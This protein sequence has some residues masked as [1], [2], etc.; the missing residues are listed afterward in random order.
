VLR[1]LNLFALLG[2]VAWLARVPDWEPAITSL[3]LLAALLGQE[4]PLLR[5]HREHDATLLKKFSADFPSQGRTALFLRDHDLGGPFRT[6]ATDDLDRFLHTWDNAEH[7]FVSQK[8]EIARKAL[9]ICGTEFRKRLSKEISMTNAG[10]FSIGMDDLEM[11]PEMFR[12]RD[13]L[14]RLA[15]RVYR[16]HQ[17]LIRAG[18]G[19]R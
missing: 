15:S 7:E 14:N 6:D 8:L 2:A 17:S 4:Y 10:F 5:K 1:L 12:K 13:E 3:G 9:M 11:R 18:K 19:M 16:A